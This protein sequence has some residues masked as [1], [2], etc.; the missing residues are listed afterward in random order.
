MDVINCKSCG[1]LFNY[2]G[3]QPLC[4]A[5]QKK[6][7]EKFDEVKQYI[8]DHPGCGMQEV[9]DEMDVSIATLKRWLKE[10]RL[11][12]S[13]NSDIALS[14]EACGKKI[15]TGRFCRECK[16]TMSNSLNNAFAKP[17]QK[18][19]EKRHVASENRM[20]FLDTDK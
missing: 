12:F 11:S 13:E 7:D 4:P 16:Q 8:Y 20:R 1:K 2:L 14:C 6:M 17:V 15:L 18:Q 19:Q 5:C 9:S 10:E 3:G